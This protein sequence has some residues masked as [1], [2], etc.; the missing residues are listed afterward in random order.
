MKK[1]RIMLLILL[2]VSLF[3]SIDLGLNFCFSLI[4]ELQD[5]IGSNSILQATFGIFGD[6]G[7][8]KAKFYYAFSKSLW[9][10]YWIFVL[11][12]SVYL[13]NIINGKI[14]KKDN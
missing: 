10:T 4:P 8:T 13:V 3:V 9:I 14:E 6:N 11:N 5:G 1:L 12:I 7:W 2:I